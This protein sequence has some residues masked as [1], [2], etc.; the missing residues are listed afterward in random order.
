M[1][2]LDKT[3]ANASQPKSNVPHENVQT[4]ILPQYF[5]LYSKSTIAMQLKPTV[6][7]TPKK[8][9]KN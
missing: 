8:A 3:I 7:N 1:T 6:D 5:F 2:E 9:K 4:Q